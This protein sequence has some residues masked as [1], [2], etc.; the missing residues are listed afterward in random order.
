MMSN[1]AVL[2]AGGVGTRF[3]PRSRRKFPKQ[4]LNIVGK[5]SMIQATFHRLKGLV[6]PSNIIIVTN[7]QQENKIGEQLTELSRN[8][9]VLEP[10]GRNTAP[11]IGLA[12]V[13]IISQDPD[14]IMIVLPADHLI[15]DV[16]EFQ[17]VINL[18]VEFASHNGGLIT[19]G[20]TPTYPSS[21]YGY[22][23]RES[24]AKEINGH[25]IYKVRTFAEKPNHE[26]AELFLSSGDFYWNSG[27]FIWK[28]STIL[29]EISNKL[30][31]IYEGLM[32]IKDTIGSV[33]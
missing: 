16:Q 27:M 2:M 5:N 30:P 12:A 33:K 20:I 29:E 23:Q 24:G 25:Q 7:P 22:I 1:Y 32:E 10:F 28:T 19:I 14:G 3:W 11:C 8:N 15:T 26:T 31:E 4:V 9:F 18:A 21:A 13:K 17:R 6:D